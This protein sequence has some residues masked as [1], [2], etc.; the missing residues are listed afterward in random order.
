MF[1]IERIRRWGLSSVP[2]IARYCG[3]KLEER[4]T[5]FSDCDEVR[6]SRPGN[7][8]FRCY[9]LDFS[10]DGTPKYPPQT[11]MSF[12]RHPLRQP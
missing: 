10:A 3:T 5:Y 12:F 8:R 4:S 7:I 2:D 1:R 9:A 6:P 11:F